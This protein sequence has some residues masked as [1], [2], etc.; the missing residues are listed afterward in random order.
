MGGVLTFAG[1]GT[2]FMLNADRMRNVW[3]RRSG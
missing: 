3:F 2:A 1:D